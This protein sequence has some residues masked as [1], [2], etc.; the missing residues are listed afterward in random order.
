MWYQYSQEMIDAFSHEKK[1]NHT[2]K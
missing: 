1:L 2:K